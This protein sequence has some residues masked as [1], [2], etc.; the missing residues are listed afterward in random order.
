MPEPTQ[1]TVR[2]ADGT[3][4]LDMWGVSYAAPMND[5]RAH[6]PMALFKYADAATRYRGDF[7]TWDLDVR[8]L[9]VTVGPYVALPFQPERG[10]RVR[11]IDCEG[12]EWIGPYL[13]PA[14]KDGHWLGG[15]IVQIRVVSV[16]P[17]EAGRG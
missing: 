8:L 12:T 13:R 14:V 15:A 4:T 1:T 10:E 6:P 5:L 9:R 11:G 3:Y 16:H 7:A 17:L 2:N